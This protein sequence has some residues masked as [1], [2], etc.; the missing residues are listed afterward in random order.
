MQLQQIND[1]CEK[2]M[3]YDGEQCGDANDDVKNQACSFDDNQVDKE[4]NKE[5][6]NETDDG[7]EEDNSFPEDDQC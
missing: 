6:E 2:W 7:E 3:C 5:E 1:T 4:D